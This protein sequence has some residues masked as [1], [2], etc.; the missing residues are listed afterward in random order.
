MKMIGSWRKGGV[1]DLV[2]SS[3]GSRTVWPIRLKPPHF[4]TIEVHDSILNISEAKVP[5]VHP[6]TV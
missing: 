4:A 6:S 1:S 2:A 5:E 3:G